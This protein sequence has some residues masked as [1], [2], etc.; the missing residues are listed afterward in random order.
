MILYFFPKH[1]LRLGVLTSSLV[2]TFVNQDFP[3]SAQ[4]R[5]LKAMY[6]IPRYL[7]LYP[8][9]SRSQ[10]RYLKPRYLKP[11]YLSLYS[12]ISRSQLSLGT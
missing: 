2:I 7:S 9:I 10:P 4:P 5:Y 6:L 3:F 1:R 12:M 11:M 8:R